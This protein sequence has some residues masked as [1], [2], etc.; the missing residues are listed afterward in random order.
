MNSEVSGCCDRTVRCLVRLALCPYAR[1]YVCGYMT[2][3]VCISV[4]V[5]LSICVRLSVCLCDSV[6][7][8]L[9]NCPSSC[10]SQSV[11]LSV[12]IIHAACPFSIH[13]SVCCYVYLSI[14]LA[15]CRSVRMSCKSPNDLNKYYSCTY[16]DP[17]T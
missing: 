17:Q 3:S 14:C 12:F 16:S 2:N 4:H 10:V 5:C 15:V 11:Y 7:D 8:D 1:L 6:G 13:S 9:D